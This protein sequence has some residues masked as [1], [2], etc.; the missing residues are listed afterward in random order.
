MQTCSAIDFYTGAFSGLY[1]QLVSG[2]YLPDPASLFHLSQRFFDVATP[3]SLL[4]VGIG[5]GLSSLPFQQRYPHLKIHG[6]DGSQSMLH[7]CRQTLPLAD[8][9]ALDCE[10]ERLPYDDKSF[11]V[12]LSQGTLYFMKDPLTVITDMTRVTRR[13]GLLIFNFEESPDSGLHERFNDATLT[14]KEPQQV[15]T[16]QHPLEKVLESLHKGGAEIVMHKKRLAMHKYS[17]PPVYFTDVI[18]KKL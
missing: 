3:Y 5:S 6:V 16:Y 13:N 10:R 8:L 17:G 4:D 1:N 2:G 9:R 14:L 18:A 12:V 15:A 11:D 7:I